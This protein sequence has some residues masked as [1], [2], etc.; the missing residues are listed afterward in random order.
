MP[1]LPWQRIEEENKGLR[2]VLL[3][4]RVYCVRLENTL[5]DYVPQGGPRGQSLHES[6]KIMGHCDRK[7]GGSCCL[8]PGKRAGDAAMAP[9]CQWG[10]D[11]VI[12]RRWDDTVFNPGILMSELE[13]RLDIWKLRLGRES[14]MLS[15]TQ[16]LGRVGLC[17]VSVR[18]WQPEDMAF[19]ALRASKALSVEVPV[20]F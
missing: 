2:K 14:D 5:P 9:R 17:V 1:E 15:A 6:N 8:R 20:G 13:E 7:S 16:Q 3:L 18:P 19:G 12:A 11:S 4:E 10:E